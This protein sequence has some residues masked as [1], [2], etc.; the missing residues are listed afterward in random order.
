MLPTGGHPRLLASFLCAFIAAAAV[1]EEVDVEALLAAPRP[2]PPRYRGIHGTGVGDAQPMDDRRYEH[3]V[4]HVSAEHGHVVLAYT[5]TLATDVESVDLDRN[6]R[7]IL[8]D[9]AHRAKSGVK[10][11]AGLG[12]SSGERTEDLRRRGKE[13]GAKLGRKAQGVMT[14]IVR[15]ATQLVRRI[16]V[17]TL[18]IAGPQWHCSWDADPMTGERTGRAVF[19]RVLAV[20][21]LGP[22]VVRLLS[23]PASMHH[24]FEH[25]KA[26]FRHWLPRSP[27]APQRPVGPLAVDERRLAPSFEWAD[28]LSANPPLVEGET[29]RSLPIGQ[30]RLDAMHEALR[31]HG[32]PS[33]RYLRST[34]RQRQRVPRFPGAHRFAGSVHSVPHDLRHFDNGTL[35][36]SPP[37]PRDA[38]AV[39]PRGGARAQ[40]EEEAP[41]T[42][43]RLLR[44]RGSPQAT[45]QSG[46]DAGGDSVAS[47]MGLADAPGT[48]PAP[49]PE[50][51]VPVEG[52]QAAAAP[53]SAAAQS[54]RA[55]H[56]PL[57]SSSATHPRSP[58]Q[59]FREVPVESGVAMEGPNRAPAAPTPAA[60]AEE[61]VYASWR[62]E[63]AALKRV[64]GQRSDWGSGVPWR[65]DYAIVANG[66][67]APDQL[68]FS[69]TGAYR[70]WEDGSV[71]VVSLPAGAVSSEAVDEVVRGLPHPNG[72][73][74]GPDDVR[75][76]VLAFREQRD[77]ADVSDS[78][79]LRAA[80]ISKA[81]ADKRAAE[82]AK[83]N[84]PHCSE[85]TNEKN[86]PLLSWDWAKDGPQPFFVAEVRRL[87]CV[88]G[89]GRGVAPPYSHAHCGPLHCR[90]VRSTPRW[91]GRTLRWTWRWR[92]SCWAAS[93][94]GPCPS[95]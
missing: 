51:A 57:P 30:M 14:L 53:P 74:I 58:R 95:G 90:G 68:R 77:G 39:C 66:T 79:Y 24:C 71:T 93:T 94:S 67:S 75:R 25:L 26:R 8:C 60:A 62:D 69:S 12:E 6:I 92:A 16:R 41:G 42:R 20:H 65:K 22:H 18:L 76:Q 85:K 54:A 31:R 49:V 63:V 1:G 19:R 5:A 21:V 91:T 73:G 4:E 50:R 55:A 43:R 37:L 46:G 70:T 10:F 61:P 23:V 29:S 13:A 86:K 87:C 2:E 9:D 89:G 44:V 15:N 84:K 11:G 80:S 7:H 78:A 48:A 45:L 28:A 33:E 36:R 38:S 64:D 34:A 35:P 72:D 88:C 59:R 40:P 56:V 52:V 82:C 32:P 17:G 3:I 83:S 81:E 27:A 47:L